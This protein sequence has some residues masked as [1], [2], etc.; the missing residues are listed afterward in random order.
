MGRPLKYKERTVVATVKVPESFDK[1]VLPDLV[2][3]YINNSSVD[4]S[5][6]K[7]MIPEFVKTGINL[8]TTTEIEDK[9]IM[10]LIKECL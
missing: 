10:E 1:K 9:R 7:K 3:Q 5:I 4:T 6:L 8:R 2:E